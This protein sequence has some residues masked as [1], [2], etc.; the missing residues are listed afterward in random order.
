MDTRCQSDAFNSAVTDDLPW[1]I[2]DLTVR[3]RGFE[4]VLRDSKG[5]GR[6]SAVYPK[7]R[8]ST[9]PLLLNNLGLDDREPLAAP[10][11]PR[12]GSERPRFPRLGVVGDRH[13]VFSR[14]AQIAHLWGS[15]RLRHQI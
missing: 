11:H 3:S 15:L 7:P 1:L 6:T 14:D 10:A 8:D 5:V 4:D 13:S 9:R 2:A 12:Y